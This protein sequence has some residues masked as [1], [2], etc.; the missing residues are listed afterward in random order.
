M[1]VIRKGKKKGIIENRFPL[2]K[3]HLVF[4]EIGF[5]FDL[6]PFK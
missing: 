1:L 5:F 6:I 2:R 4:L 3:A